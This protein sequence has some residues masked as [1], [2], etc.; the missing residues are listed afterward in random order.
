MK[1]HGQGTPL[2]R[3]VCRVVGVATIVAA[4]FV[5]YRQQA[6][7]GFLVAF[8]GLSIIGLAETAVDYQ[9]KLTRRSI[10][11]WMGSRSNIS[12]LGQMCNIASYFCLAAA[13]VSWIA[14]R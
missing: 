14:L 2:L 1:S 4:G 13:L 11:N 9:Q 10:G 5:L 8:V 6:V 12:T 3:L 7:Q